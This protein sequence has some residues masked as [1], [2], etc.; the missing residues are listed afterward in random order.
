MPSP[1]SPQQHWQPLENGRW[2]RVVGQEGAER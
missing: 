2:G 1:P